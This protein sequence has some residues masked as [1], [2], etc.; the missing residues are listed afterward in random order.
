MAQYCL[1][2]KTFRFLKFDQLIIELLDLKEM[3]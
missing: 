1:N 2:Y 3:K